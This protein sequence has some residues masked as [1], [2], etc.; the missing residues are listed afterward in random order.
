MKNSKNILLLFIT[1]FLFSN[2]IVETGND[3]YAKYEQLSPLEMNVEIKLGN[4]EIAETIFFE[5]LSDLLN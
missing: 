2:N 3:H 1:S 5:D 4:F